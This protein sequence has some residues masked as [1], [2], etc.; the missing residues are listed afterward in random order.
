MI[1]QSNGTR[2]PAAQTDL[3]LQVPGATLR[4]WVSN[5][6][7]S[8]ALVYFGGNAEQVGVYRDIVA[9]QFP[10]H[11]TYLMAYRGYGA[12]D[13]TPSEVALVRDGSAILQEAA[14]RH[15][16]APVAILGRSLGSA[17][18]IQVAAQ[19]PQIG[20]LVLVTPFDSLAAVIRDLM[21]GMPVEGFVADRF[22][23]RAL[24]PTITTRTLVIRAGRDEV[25]PAA[26][27]DALVAALPE[28][29]TTVRNFPA[30]D[31]NSVSGDAEYWATI[32]RF[33][34]TEAA[35]V[36]YRSGSAE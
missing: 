20:A 3:S 11:A 19:H 30:A 15:P 27:T 31:H 25:I 7:A 33:L 1:F 24:A 32:R 28:A 13:G 34:E 16:D 35:Q 26:R 2:V 6:G 22:D 5:P 9:A 8:Q 4:G 29:L 21:R 18:A 36:E 12:S 14:R 17:V 10:R 23:S